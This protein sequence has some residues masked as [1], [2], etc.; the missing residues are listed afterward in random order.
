MTLKGLGTSLLVLLLGCVGATVPVGA[1]ADAGP[2]EPTR[3]EFL[4]IAEW[5][6]VDPGLDPQRSI[7][8]RDIFNSPRGCTS[9][10]KRWHKSRR[11]IL[12]RINLAWGTGATEAD[13]F[14]RWMNQTVVHFGTVAE[15]KS[16]VRTYQHLSRSCVG[17]RKI[18]NS[19][20]V[21]VVVKIR[22]WI[23]PK[24]GAQSGGFAECV[25][26]RDSSS[27]GRTLVVRVR[28]TVTVLAFSYANSG[29]PKRSV[30]L[31]AGEMAVPKLR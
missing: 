15:A 12:T 13:D 29:K 14:S 11:Q 6:T 5:Q 7:F 22:R 31:R 2:P 23:P 26:Y 24:M 16:F 8:V 10:A 25:C 3:G 4:T 17:N 20:G 9:E 27:W 19:D 18:K 30:V 21:P 1:G 28:R